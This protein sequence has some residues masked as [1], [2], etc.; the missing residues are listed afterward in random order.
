MKKKEIKTKTLIFQDWGT[1]FGTTMVVC[2]FDDYDDV[3]KYLKKNKYSDWYNALKWKKEDDGKKLDKSFHFSHWDMI[4]FKKGK[5]EKPIHYSVLYLLHWKSDLEH[6]K[7]LAH[8][9]FHAMQFC[10]P[11]FLDVNKE[12]EAVAY[13]HSYLFQGIADELNKIYK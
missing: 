11:V 1:F 7:I 13:E 5:E 4:S 8:E 3:L 9:L 2:G 10:M 12:Y 6:Y